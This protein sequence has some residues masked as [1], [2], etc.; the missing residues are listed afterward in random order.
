[1][2]HSS[3][4]TESLSPLDNVPHPEFQEALK[5]GEFII[6]WP[7]LPW[8]ETGPYTLTVLYHDY[9]QNTITQTY[10]LPFQVI[11]P[12]QPH[13]L[14]RQPTQPSSNEILVYYTAFTP[15]LSHGFGLYR[16][17]NPQP[18]QRGIIPQREMQLRH[19]WALRMR[20]FQPATGVYWTRQ[21]LHLTSTSPITGAFGIGYEQELVKIR[22][23]YWFFWLR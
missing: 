10:P 19:K 23:P 22:Y 7:A 8:Y 14:I 21:K 3:G 12:T 5:G 6:D 13:I 4:F 11:T 15:T 2:T 18:P 17:K 1:M 16:E 9:Q 20:N